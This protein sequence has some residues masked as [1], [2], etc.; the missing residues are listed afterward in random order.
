MPNL[1]PEEGWYAHARACVC[2]RECLLR[3]IS[4]DSCG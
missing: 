3:R 1:A 4:V 2:I